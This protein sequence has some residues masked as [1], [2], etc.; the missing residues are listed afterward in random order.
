MMFV[1]QRW[2]VAQ[3]LFALP[4]VAGMGTVV[5]TLCGLVPGRVVW[6]MLESGTCWISSGNYFDITDCHEGATL[7]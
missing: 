6:N 2:R 4:P 1:L 5:K 7:L 3:D